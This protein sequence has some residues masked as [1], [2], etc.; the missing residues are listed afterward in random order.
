M[1]FR[2][3]MK[4]RLK[5]V[6]NEVYQALLDYA[7]KSKQELVIIVSLLVFLQAYILIADYTSFMLH[8]IIQQLIQKILIVAVLVNIGYTSATRL[9]SDVPEP[10]RWYMYVLHTG[11][12]AVAGALIL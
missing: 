2:S 3:Y 4:D 5:N 12:F 1:S 8:P 9:Y 7:R 6:V 11:V 10:H